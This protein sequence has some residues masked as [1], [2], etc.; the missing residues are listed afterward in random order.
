V[1]ARPEDEFEP[2]FVRK[3]EKGLVA[4]TVP[5][6]FMKGIRNLS[7]RVDLKEQVT[8]FKLKGSA[9]RARVVDVLHEQ[10]TAYRDVELATDNS[11]SVDSASMYASIETFNYPHLE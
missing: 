11:G 2:K 3:K 1:N 8:V 5:Q 6:A 4:R 9:A 10:F 7:R